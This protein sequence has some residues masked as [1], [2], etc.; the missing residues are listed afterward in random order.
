[1]T[2]AAFDRSDTGPTYEASLVQ[3]IRDRFFEEREGFEQAAANISRGFEALDEAD[4]DV[5]RVAQIAGAISLA[6]EQLEVIAKSL[7]EKKRT[8]GPAMMSGPT[9][10]PISNTHSIVVERA[11]DVVDICDDSEIPDEY[12]L[13]PKA[14]QEPDKRKLKARMK[15]LGVT[16]LY[17]ARLISGDT[18]PPVVKIVSINGASS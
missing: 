6:A 16:D 4:C 17:G 8:L 14:K 13:K 10:I 11:Q 1:M 5:W 3:P 2:V 9:E 7:K 18:R 15:K 12:R